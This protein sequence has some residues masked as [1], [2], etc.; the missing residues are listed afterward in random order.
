KGKWQAPTAES[1]I[2]ALEAKF[3]T[4]Q[5]QAAKRSKSPQPSRGDAKKPRLEKPKWLKHNVAPLDKNEVKK[6]G[7]FT[8]YY[9]CKETGGKCGG[10]WRTHKPT[11]CRGSARKPTPVV[12]KPTRRSAP[13]VTLQQAYQTLVHSNSDDDEMMDE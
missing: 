4:L 13:R 3:D 12:D 11:E 8:Y 5:K 9:C 6:W 7:D 10:V 1:K 2:L